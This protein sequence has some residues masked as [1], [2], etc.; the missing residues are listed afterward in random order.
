MLAGHPGQCADGLRPPLY[1]RPDLLAL[2]FS[3]PHKSSQVS[4]PRHDLDP[5][6]AEV[7]CGPGYILLRY[8]LDALGGLRKV[9]L[10]RPFQLEVPDVGHHG[11]EAPTR[12][13]VVRIPW[14][15]DVGVV[16]TEVPYEGEDPNAIS[17]PCEGVPLGHA[18]LAVKEVA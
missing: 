5:H 17:N 8:H 12:P 2:Y 11:P 10:G 4:A 1:L 16:S 9:S 15:R 13:R 6:P 18:L 7:L 14:L 3:L